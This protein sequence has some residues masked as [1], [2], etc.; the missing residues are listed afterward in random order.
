MEKYDKAPK[1]VKETV[2]HTIDVEGGYSNNPHDIGGATKYGITERVARNYGYRGDMKDLSMSLAREIYV[3]LYY[4]KPRL[5]LLASHS[6]LITKEVFDTGVNCG[7]STAVKILQRCLNG[8]NRQ[9]RLYPDLDMDG[10][11]GLKTKEA[12]VLFLEAR[13]SQE[14]E[15]MLFNLLNCVQGEYYL[16]LT[17]STSTNEHFLYGWLRHRTTFLEI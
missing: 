8:L 16:S 13:G 4:L 7:T 1:F 2:D 14:G 3:D 10:I 9:E 11:M 5:D 17:E 15:K 6:K 12:L